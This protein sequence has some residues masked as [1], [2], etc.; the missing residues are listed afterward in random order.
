MQRTRKVISALLAIVMLVSVFSINA[1]AGAPAPADGSKVC[2]AYELCDESGN[3]I[4]QVSPNQV[5]TLKVYFN[6]SVANDALASF[7][8]SVYYDGDIYEY[9]PDSVEWLGVKS[10]IDAANSNTTALGPNSSVPTYTKSAAVWTAEEKAAHPNWTTFVYVV[11]TPL[12][13]GTT[14]YVQ[15]NADAPAYSLKFKVSE[16]ATAGTNADFGCPASV[17]LVKRESF[18]H[19]RTKNTGT[20]GAGEVAPTGVCSVTVA[21]GETP[22]VGPVLNKEI[23]QVKMTLTSATTVAEPFQYRVISKISGDDWNTYFANTGKEG[24]TTKAITSVGFVAYRGAAPFDMQMAKDVATGVVN[25]NAD[26]AT[27]ETDYI[28]YN[29]SEARFGC[30]IDFTSKPENDVTYIAFAKYLDADGQP[31]IVFY[32]EA[33]SSPVASDYTGMV[34][35]YIGAF[36]DTFV[37]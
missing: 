23:S 2:I 32:N 17:I 31:Q 20:I 16:N 8:N 13:G 34:N 10:W 15:E 1:L 26:Y 14:Y 11:G 7:L 29:G 22:V 24:A 35:A 21:G 28:Q 12:T 30:R 4:T 9:V 3:P 18:Q 19:I 25:G 6:A 36:G 37:G 33:Y 27:K 5:V